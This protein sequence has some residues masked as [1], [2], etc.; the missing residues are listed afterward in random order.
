MV[1]GQPPS[2]GGR[3]SRVLMWFHSDLRTADNA[4]L[5]AASDRASVPGGVF[6]PFVATSKA[7]TPDFLSAVVRLRDEM[8][9]SGTSLVV[10]AASSA[11]VGETLLGLVRQYN[12]QQ[13]V[14]N[15]S[16][17]AAPARV[18]AA[19][20]QQL[21]DAGVDVEAFWSNTLHAPLK[22]KKNLPGF[23]DAVAKLTAPPPTQAPSHLP[24]SP[25]GAAGVSPV[26]A[27]VNAQAAAGVLRKAQASL[28]S[29][30]PGRILAVKAALELGVVSPRMVAEQLRSTVAKGGKPA[31]A[32]G[33][34][35]SELVWRSYVAS[36]VARAEVR[37]AVGV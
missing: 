32:A 2:A 22:E 15:H 14:F 37:T 36:T 8:T 18:E 23:V 13:V 20:V 35:M 26:P 10:R 31:R 4:A 16:E 28:T 27:S 6:V 21:A 30:R 12:I 11:S 17:M 1:F 25:Q 7:S 24:Q 33:A 29:T 9:A 3:P 5:A 19:V 34:L